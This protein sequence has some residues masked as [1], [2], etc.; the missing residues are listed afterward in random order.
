MWE[1]RGG[2]WQY[3]K[4]VVGLSRRVAGQDTLGE[5]FGREGVWQRRVQ[6]EK[7][8]AGE[9]TGLSCSLQLSAPSLLALIRERDSKPRKDVKEVSIEGRGQKVRK[10]KETMKDR[11]KDEPRKNVFGHYATP[12]S[13]DTAKSTSSC[14]LRVTAWCCLPL[15]PAAAPPAMG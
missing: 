6:Q 13:G 15:T 3:G 12:R 14:S 7:G 4:S 9:G 10:M 1:G 8:V 2:V 11:G 5:A